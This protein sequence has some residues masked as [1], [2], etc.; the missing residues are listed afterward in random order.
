MTGRPRKHLFAALLP[1][2]FLAGSCGAFMQDVFDGEDGPVRFDQ[3][4]PSSERTRG[5]IWSKIITDARIRQLA[6]KVGDEGQEGCAEVVETEDGPVCRRHETPMLTVDFPYQAEGGRRAIRE[7]AF[8]CEEGSIYWYR[9]R[10]LEPSR[11]KWM[12]P[13]PVRLPRKQGR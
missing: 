8:F 4:E 1:L 11:E 2:A 12:G 7:R 9:W 5:E 6:E 10:K 13:F 3:D